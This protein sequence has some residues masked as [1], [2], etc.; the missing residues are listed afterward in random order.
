MKLPIFI[1]KLKKYFSLPLF[2]LSVNYCLAQ[3]ESEEGP[4]PITADDKDILITKITEITDKYLLNW[5]GALAVIVLIIGG[6][7]YITSAGSPE[8]A[9]AAK[10]A[11]TAG[12]IGLIIIIVGKALLFV[13]AKLL[14][15]S[16]DL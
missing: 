5:A 1:K 11:L 16:L 4:G 6:L 9:G 2:F 3:A 12:I 7:M 14:G 8:R 10:K 13:T 15:G